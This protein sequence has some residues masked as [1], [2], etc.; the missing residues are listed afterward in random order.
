[1]VYGISMQ[2]HNEGMESR[3][4]WGWN[5]WNR[6]VDENNNTC[7]MQVNIGYQNES[8]MENEDEIKMENEN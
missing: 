6:D 7:I 1:M 8:K 4:A 5:K 3:I 2:N